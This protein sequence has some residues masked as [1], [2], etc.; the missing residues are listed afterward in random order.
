MQI[1]RTANGNIV[2][3]FGFP[4][5]EYGRACEA[6]GFDVEYYNVD[7]WTGDHGVIVSI[8][9]NRVD[10]FLEFAQKCEKEWRIGRVWKLVI[11]RIQEIK[12]GQT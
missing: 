12:E 7:G 8:P 2:I 6:R 1:H 4:R 5:N 11:E 3:D 9:Q 10:E